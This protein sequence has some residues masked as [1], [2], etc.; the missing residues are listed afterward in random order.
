MGATLF[1]RLLASLVLLSAFASAQ[2]PALAEANT[3]SNAQQTP[4]IQLQRIGKGVSAPVAIKTPQ[5]KYTR[6]AREEKIEGSCILSII[7]DPNGIPQNVKVVRA[8][9]HGLDES[10]LAAVKKYRFRPAMKDGRAVAVQIMIKVNFK[11]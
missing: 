2:Q 5:A 8:L 3:Q 4:A 10:A 11:L 6:E 1:I 7:V 9:G